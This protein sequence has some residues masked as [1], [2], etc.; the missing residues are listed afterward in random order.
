MGRGNCE[1][2]P[3][4]FARSVRRPDDEPLGAG[5]AKSSLPVEAWRDDVERKLK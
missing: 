1:A 3:N 5:F 2:L 4:F